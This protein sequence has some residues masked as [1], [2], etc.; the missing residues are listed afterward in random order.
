MIR[1]HSNLQYPLVRLAKRLDTLA[2]SEMVSYEELAETVE[3]MKVLINK[4]ENLKE[5]Q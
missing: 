4:L 2:T 1:L 5:D 3:A